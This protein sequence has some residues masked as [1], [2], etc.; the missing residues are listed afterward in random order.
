MIKKTKRKWDELDV[1]LNKVANKQ[2]Q[3]ASKAL[4][5]EHIMVEGTLIWMVTDS[6]KHNKKLKTELDEVKH[7]L[8]TYKKS[9]KVKEEIQAENNSICK[10]L[11]PYSPN[12]T[13]I[14]TNYHNLQTHINAKHKGQ[15]KVKKSKK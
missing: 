8:E 12:S 11:C 6:Q 9:Q 10:E 3:D 14:Y 2:L 15:Q 7:E 4:E 5:K 13:K 1:E